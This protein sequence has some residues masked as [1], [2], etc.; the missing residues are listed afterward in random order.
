MTDE[1]KKSATGCSYL[2]APCLTIIIQVWYLPHMD[3]NDIQK[4]YYSIADLARDLKVDPET[5][6]RR[7][8][9]GKIK[10]EKVGAG[11]TPYVITLDEYLRIIRNGVIDE[12]Q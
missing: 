4:N 8:I 11:K 6:R 9:A 7:I 12:L 10:A 3:S 2:A 1:I 5:I